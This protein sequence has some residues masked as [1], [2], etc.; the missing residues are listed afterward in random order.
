MLDRLSIRLQALCRKA[1]I[2]RDLDDELRYHIEKDIERNLGRGMSQAEARQAAMRAFGGVQQIKEASRDAR[3]VVALENLWRDLRYGAMMLRKRPGLT[4]TVVMTLALA[5]GANTAL[6]SIVHAYLFRLL[7]VK[8]PQQLVFVH[9]V[10]VAE[11]RGDFHYPTFEQFRAR[12]T[13]FD[14][15]FAR[16]NTRVSVTVDGEADLLWADFVTG[17]YFELLGIR[18]TIGRTFSLGDDKPAQAPVAVISYGYW[19]RRFARDPAAVG[20]AIYVGRIPFTIVGVTPASFR[21]LNVAGRSADLIMPMFMQRQL[22]L[23]DHDKFEV[24]S[25]MK[26]GVTSEQARADLDTIYQELMARQPAPDTSP[27]AASEALDQRIEL[28]PALRGH[29]DLGPGDKRELRILMAVVGIVLV[30]AMINVANLLLASGSSRQMEI[31]VRLAMGAG[32]GR[33]IRQ[34]L[35]ESLLLALLGGAGG[36]LFARWGVGL[37]LSLL[38]FDPDP[39]PSGLVSD[40]EVL[41]FTSVVALLTGI[42]FGLAPAI[43]ATKVDLNPVLKE[44][45]SPARRTRGWLGKSLIASQVALSVSLLISAGLLL[46]SLGGLHQVDLGFERER[47]LTMWAFPILMGYQPAQE[48]ELYRASLEK[49]NAIPGV[50][51]ASLSRFVVGRGSGPVGPRFFETMGIALIKGREFT[52]GDTHQSARVA[53]INESMARKAFPD[54]DPIGR[55]LPVDRLGLEELQGAGAV[56]VVGVVRDIRRNLR[57]QESD[58]VYY[59]PYTQ[60]PSGWLGQVNFVVRTAVSPPSLIPAVRQALQAV[61]RDLPLVGI[62]TVADQ[63]YEGSLSDEQSLAIL[64]GLFGGLGM[65]MAAIGLYGTMSYDVVRRTRELGIRMALGAERHR[66]VRMV[67]G[68]TLSVFGTGAALGILLAAGASRLISSLLF[69]VTATDPMTVA[70]ALTVILTT[71]L[72]AGYIPA[73][74]ASRI[75]PNVALRYE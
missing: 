52:E 24:V 62:R 65:L 69:G 44:G 49:L 13:S 40:A 72:V 14:G 57:R 50:Q 17:E 46:R 30:I 60:A 58:S 35:N 19:Q 7:Q 74:R 33:I 23:S 39:I 59:T 70:A 67:L 12:N 6:F 71:A 9:R 21:G 10:S 34:L 55:A 75:D 3:G 53:I 38:S 5:I 48:L 16:D 73:R 45:G 37:L 27:E 1:R 32:R 41:V 15:L 66:V 4:F 68:E 29:S 28:K 31:A 64:I 51:A 36:W 43:A 42:M 25:R 22:A 11:E 20:K 61:D 8:D 2:E 26:P 54:Q 56:Q 47:V 18:P 63:I